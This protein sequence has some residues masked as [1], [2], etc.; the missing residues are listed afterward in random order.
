MKNKDKVISSSTVKQ[1]GKNGGSFTET[2]KSKSTIIDSNR[3]STI[4]QKV[5]KGKA[6]T[7]FKSVSTDNSGQNYL[8]KGSDGG[9][10]TK[11]KITKGRAKR[12][13]NRMNN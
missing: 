9:N 10:F 7:K 1:K 8:S 3:T 6:S 13:K 12:I 2:F 4:K 11:R 5:K